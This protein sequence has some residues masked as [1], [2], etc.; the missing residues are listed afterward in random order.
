MLDLTAIK[1]RFAGSIKTYDEHALVQKHVAVKLAKFIQNTLSTIPERILEVGCGTGLLTHQL[2]CSYPDAHYY[3]NDINGQ[4][5]TILPKILPNVRYDFLPGDAQH[6][7]WPTELDLVVS[8]STLQ[9]FADPCHFFQSIKQALSPHGYFIFST[10]G[11]T[12]LQ[13]ITAITGKG[14]YYPSPEQLKA[15]LN[16]EFIVLEQQ[17]ETIQLIFDTPLQVLNHL[18]YTGVNAGFNVIKNKTQLTHF[19]KT[20]EAWFSMM[21]GVTLTY[22]PIYF[23]AQLRPHYPALPCAKR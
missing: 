10:F 13:E 14:L 9:W 17:E 21:P 3:L 7:E 1:K 16:A 15:W 12:N 18:K 11:E 4:I 2:S 23:I 22:H 20:Y 8:A 6:K 5:E 19:C